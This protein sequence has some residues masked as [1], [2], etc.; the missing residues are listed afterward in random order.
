MKK[1]SKD[2]AKNRIIKLVE[3][4]EENVKN[5][6]Q[7]VPEGVIR[8]NYIDKMFGYLNWDVRN[9]EL[10]PI[11]EE[12]VKEEENVE[13]KGRKKRPDYTF[14]FPAGKPIFFLEA[15]S[16]T[17]VKISTN[18]DS[19][20]QLRSYGWSSGFF[21]SVLTNF[22][23]LAIYNTKNVEPNKNDSASKGRLEILKYTEYADR[24]DDIWELFEFNNVAEGSI[25]DY[26]IQK[27][28][29]SETPIKGS[30]TVDEAFLRDI[31][32]WRRDLAHIINLRNQGISKH[33]LNYSVQ[34][35]I[36][37]IIFLRIAEDRDIQPFGSLKNATNYSALCKLFRDADKKYNS[38]LFHFS[39]KKNRGIPDTITP[40]L[41]IDDNTIQD[42]INPLY[43][44]C[45]YAFD[46][47][48][49]YILG[50]VYERFLGKEVELSKKKI[51]IDEK[52]AVRK[53]G[54][55][56]YTPEHIVEYIIENTISQ[57]SDAKILDPACGSG[58]F[59]LV[60][61]QYMLNFYQRKKTNSKLTLA[62]RKQILLDHIFGVDLDEQ[63]VEVAKL[64]LLLKVLEGVTKNEIDK[65]QKGE[66]VLPDLYKNIK[67][68]NSLI[69]D[70]TVAGEKAFV[71]EEEFPEI[72]DSNKELLE[73]V[74]FD[75]VI[76]NPPYVQFQK[77]KENSKN[78]SHYQTYSATGDI[79]CIFYEQGMNLLKPNGHLGFITSNKWMR[80]G[81]GEKLRGLFSQYNP[82]YLIDLSG[83][84][85]FDDATV[86][87]NILIIQKR[88]NQNKTT[89]CQV[90]EKM[91]DP[92]KID[93][94]NK[95]LEQREQ[96]K[97]H[98]TAPIPKFNLKK[99]VNIKENH[100]VCAFNTSDAWVI[101]NEIESQIKAKIETVGTPL[102]DWDIKINFGIKTGFNE[103]FIIDEERRS[104]LLAD[105]PNSDEIIKP[106]LRGRDIERY[107][108]KWAGLYL[109][110]T[111]NGIKN[112]N[113]PRVDVEDYPAVK[114]H[115]DNY[116]KYLEKRQ[117]QGDT[118]YNL[119][120]CAYLDEFEKE[121]IIYAEICVEPR[122]YLD[123][124]G[125]F[126]PEATSF[127][128]TGD[129]IKYIYCFL[130]HPIITFAFKKFYAGGGLGDKGYRY[131]KQFVEK[132]PIPIPDKKT[133]RQIEK[134]LEK[135]NY[136]KI[137]EIVFGLYGLTEE[138]II[139]IIDP[140]KYKEEY[141]EK[142]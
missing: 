113:I 99:Y 53:A 91:I 89:A 30:I 134:L 141:E 7:S 77:D 81:Y 125:S 21:I 95:R 37:R 73:G 15:K 138:E 130:H 27:R 56:Y 41:R 17:A 36:D 24:F 23:E 123:K 1:Y 57:K 87:C 16:P 86:D 52:P 38:G 9:E 136:D 102:K 75:C 101:T 96:G 128:M 8:K 118:P 82:K 132:I 140:E 10:L 109:I 34:K 131:K 71:W 70:V 105:Y 83:I 19:A 127:I 98:R 100:S 35:I 50:S 14:C 92:R 124:D 74:G 48:P 55:V 13:V 61:Y 94:H 26:A 42:I 85:I 137:D 47:L 69:D 78:Y 97:L 76:G 40:N 121:K 117:D 22:E 112:K 122:F 88:K 129:R 142:K 120:D 107:N 20:F 116:Y 11:D 31:E 51:S 115:L 29:I 80:A 104:V 45:K 65:L 58:S 111:H 72:F 135:K 6:N 62:E 4:F 64:S 32:I 84:K 103:A 79:Y 25:I 33:D 28:I 114:E 133:E 110:N 43:A 2:E 44:G 106:I 12:Y 39:D 5:T 108:Y 59:L 54:G 119:R 46:V 3:H 60:A 49:A 66:Y 126:F 67:C 93:E 139:Y 90:K 18:I 63:A 68:G